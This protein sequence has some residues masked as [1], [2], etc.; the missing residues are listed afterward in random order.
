MGNNPKFSV[1]CP[2]YNAEKTIARTI[3]SIIAQNYR[4]WEL[5]VID[6]G[7]SDSTAVLAK[8][9]ADEDSRIK[10]IEQNNTGQAG[11]RNTGLRQ[12]KGK[13]ILFIDSDDRYEPGAF[14]QLKNAIIKNPSADIVL[15]GFN[16]FRNDKLLRTPHPENSIFKSNELNKFLLIRKLFISACNKL[17]R[18]EYITESFDSS[19]VHGEDFRFNYQNMKQGMI[20]VA[21]PDCLY[22]VY[23]DTENSVNKRYKKGRLKDNVL[24]ACIEL[25][26]ND[27]IFGSEALLRIIMEESINVIAVCIC[28]SVLKLPKEECLAEFE[29]AYVCLGNNLSSSSKGIKTRFDNKIVWTLFVNKHFELLYYICKIITSAKDTLKW[30]KNHG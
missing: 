17:Y 15:F 2:A 27:E 24:N 16:I 9:Y 7:S 29:S 21:I 1:I 19:I 13:W 18:R 30:L 23:L 6:D 8:Q 22:D 20:V 26:R 12:A 14:I 5:I 3:D 10:V 4:D 11:A 25:K 28:L